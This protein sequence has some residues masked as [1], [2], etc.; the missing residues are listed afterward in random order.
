MSKMN[1]TF[2]FEDVYSGQIHYVNAS[3]LSDAIKIFES[4][5]DSYVSPAFDHVH[6]YVRIF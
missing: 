2:A 1:M 5:K 6:V 4:E 3:D